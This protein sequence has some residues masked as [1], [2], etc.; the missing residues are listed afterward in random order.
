MAVSTIHIGKEIEKRLQNLKISKTE[1]GRRIG[2]P[3]QNVNRI[4][5]KDTIDT[6]KLLQ[7]SN[8]L[9]FNFFELYCDPHE[10]VHTEGDLS[11]ASG[12][13]DVEVIVGDAVLME[14]VKSLNTLIAEKDE[15]IAE[16]KERIEEL[17]NK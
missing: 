13:G 5:D 17:K 1:F 16:L 11:P 8:A 2:I 3:Q 15:R 6:G 12:S 10:E 4:I 14:R 9:N 7:I